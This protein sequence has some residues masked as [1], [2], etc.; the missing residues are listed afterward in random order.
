MWKQT[1]YNS[2]LFFYIHAWFNLHCIAYFT[3]NIEIAMHITN[4][5]LNST[6]ILQTQPLTYF[7]QLLGHYHANRKWTSHRRISWLPVNED[8]MSKI[9]VSGYTES[10]PTRHILIAIKLKFH[11]EWSRIARHFFQS[12]TIILVGAQ[13]RVQQLCSR[14]IVL[15]G[16][17]TSTEVS[18]VLFQLK[19][20]APIIYLF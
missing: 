9:R 12:I 3:S 17:R 13:S 18:F 20:S 14:K 2:L 16:R 5:T 8:A 6:L 1:P 10:G 19:R 15:K 4:T 11:F 7:T